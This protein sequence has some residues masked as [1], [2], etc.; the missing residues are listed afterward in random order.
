MMSRMVSPSAAYKQ[1]DNHRG[2]Q[3][4]DRK[5]RI[6]RAMWPVIRWIELA[7]VFLDQRLAGNRRCNLAGR[8]RSLFSRQHRTEVASGPDHHH[9][10]CQREQ[11]I[12]TVGNGRSETR[13]KR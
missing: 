7:R 3:H 11:R 6:D 1:A 12:E 9:D 4:A 8:A 2:H 13:S 10:E 5:Q